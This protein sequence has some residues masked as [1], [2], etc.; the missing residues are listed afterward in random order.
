VVVPDR[1]ERPSRSGVLEVRIEG[2]RGPGV[3]AKDIVLALLARI[4]VG[5]GTGHVFDYTGSAVGSL[6]MEERMTVCNM[7]IEG[8]ARAGM[9]APDDTTFEYIAGREFSP[10]GQEWDRSLARWRTLPTD[11]G[12]V[13]DRSLTL[14]ISGLSP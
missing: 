4:G 5:G 7:S 14:D 6:T 8:G 13:F 1:D 10:R 9:M 3:T 11:P 12:A 2:K